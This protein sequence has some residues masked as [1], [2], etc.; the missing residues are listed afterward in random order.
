MFQTGWFG[1]IANG[2]ALTKQGVLQPFFGKGGLSYTAQGELF[3]RLFGISEGE[4]PFVLEVEPVSGLSVVR[5]TRNAKV[6][7]RSKINRA[8]SVGCPVARTAFTASEDQVAFLEQHGHLGEAS[9]FQAD[10]RRTT[11]PGLAKVT[12]GAYTAI[13]DVLWQWGDFV[14]RYAHHLLARGS[15]PSGV[16]ATSANQAVLLDSEL[17][18]PRVQ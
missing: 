6:A 10:E 11:G 14:G 7:V 3:Q 12:Q 13:D 9:G 1:D 8:Q 16:Q 15:D 17:Q 2:M 5:L 4:E 18:I